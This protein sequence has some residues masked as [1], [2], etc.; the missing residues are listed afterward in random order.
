MCTNYVY[1]IPCGRW[2]IDE[3]ATSSAFQHSG[4]TSQA[5]HTPAIGSLGQSVICFSCFSKDWARRNKR[6][7]TKTSV[8]GSPSSDEG[9]SGEDIWQKE[10]D[11]FVANGGLELG[12]DIE[13]STTC[14]EIRG[15]PRGDKNGQK[16]G[17]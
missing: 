3:N 11:E 6:I 7:S 4:E 2:S 12:I 14:L 16:A 15:D 17:K 5:T 13:T 10:F 9:D 8:D 1:N